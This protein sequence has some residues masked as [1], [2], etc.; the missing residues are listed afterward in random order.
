MAGFPGETLEDH[1]QNLDLM[2]AVK[3]DHLGAFTYSKEEGT[4][5]YNMV[6]DVPQEEKERRK[7]EIMM[8][9]DEIVKEAREALIGQEAEVLIEG[10]EPLTQMYLGR[11]V[12][13]APDGVDGVVRVKSQSKLEIGSFY[14]TKYTRVSGQNMIAEVIEE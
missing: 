4:P 13:F 11:S 8:L 10:Y 2:K 5:S 1:K 14:Q 7:K 3:W 6:D 12:L 9:Q